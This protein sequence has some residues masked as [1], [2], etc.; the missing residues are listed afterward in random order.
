M[1]SQVIELLNKSI[2]SKQKV[3]D[4]AE[5]RIVNFQ[6]QIDLLNAK[7][8]KELQIYKHKQTFLQKIKPYVYGFASGIIVCTVAGKP[9]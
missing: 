5:L 1:Q 7:H 6:K 8:E 4:I 3:I 2:E 9:P